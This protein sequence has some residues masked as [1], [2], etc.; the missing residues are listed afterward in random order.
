ME[1]DTIMSISISK[2][3]ITFAGKLAFLSKKLQR[4]EEAFDNE[5]Q[6]YTYE[7]TEAEWEAFETIQTLS[8]EFVSDLWDVINLLHPSIL[9]ARNIDEAKEMLRE[10]SRSRS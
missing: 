9:A 2:I 1:G 6:T 5:E 4:A 7:M 3:P 10:E 8:S